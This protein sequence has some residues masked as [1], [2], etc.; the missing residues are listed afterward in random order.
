MHVCGV[1]AAAFQP[2]FRAHAHLD[3]QRREPW[4]LPETYFTAV[5]CAVITRYR[6]LP[7][8]YWLFYD[9][10]HTGAPVMRP[11]WLE[12]PADRS[13][14]ADEEQHFVGSALLVHP[15]TQRGV[16]VIQVYLP[17][18][19]QVYQCSGRFTIVSLSLF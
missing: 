18:D 17:G 16:K 1:K 13:T 5:R 11:M 8:W 19:S 15:V 4:L 9:S 2:F 3:T 10:E 14:F 7:Y 12:F 6:L